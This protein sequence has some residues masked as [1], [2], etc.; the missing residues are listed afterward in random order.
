MQDR[1]AKQRAVA[2]SNSSAFFYGF[3]FICIKLTE[4]TK[5][6]LSFFGQIKCNAMSKEPR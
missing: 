3:I 1:V 6:M 5:T 4:A 2:L